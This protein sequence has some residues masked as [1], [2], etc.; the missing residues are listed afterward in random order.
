[1]TRQAC[2][3]AFAAAVTFL[4]GGASARGASH[5]ERILLPE[6]ALGRPKALVLAPFYKELGGGNDGTDAAYLQL[7]DAGYDVT[8]KCDEFPDVVPKDGFAYCADF[9]I[10]VDDFKHFSDYAFVFLGGHG[11]AEDGAFTGSFLLA[12]T[13]ITWDPALH[14]PPNNDKWGPSQHGPISSDDPYGPLWHTEKGFVALPPEFFAAYTGLSSG[15]IV[16]FSLCHGARSSLFADVFLSKGFG[17]FIGYTDVVGI[18]FAAT[19]SNAALACLLA[20]GGVATFPPTLLE[21]EPVDSSPASLKAYSV[22]MADVKIP[23]C[24]CVDQPYNMLTG[25]CDCA[26]GG[27][28]CTA[29]TDC[30]EGFTCEP[31]PAYTVPMTVGEAPYTCQ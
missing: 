19:Q 5:P 10:T 7:L 24:V 1:M 17:A 23:A 8:F 18:E 14:G 25:T 31:S 30:C 27:V 15:G 26:S 6:C 28:S 21:P 9:G 12:N 3:A 20:G 16:L 29:D 2:F 22:D 4:S 13:N 11:Y